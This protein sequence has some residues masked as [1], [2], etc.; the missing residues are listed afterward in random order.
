[1]DPWAKVARS[2]RDL[3]SSL[4]PETQY[5]IIRMQPTLQVTLGLCF[6]LLPKG[7]E[8]KER[9]EGRK[10]GREGRRKEIKNEGTNE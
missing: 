7:E 9:P 3:E 10:E 2:T 1:M 5:S 4:L 8:E 6:S